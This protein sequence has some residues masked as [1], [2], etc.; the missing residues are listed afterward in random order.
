M[1]VH[2]VYR[3]KK[4]IDDTAEEFKKE[5]YKTIGVKVDEEGGG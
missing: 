2:S 3:L 1:R 4:I 5:M